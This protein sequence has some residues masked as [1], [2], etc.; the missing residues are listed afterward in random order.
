MQ[1]TIMITG[2]SQIAIEELYT[3]VASLVGEVCLLKSKPITEIKGEDDADIFICGITQIDFLVQ[4]VPRNKIL[5][6]EPRFTAEFF[7]NV[8]K[9]PT[10]ADVCVFH[11]N[12]FRINMIIQ[13]LKNMGFNTLNFIPVADTMPKETIHEKLS[14]VRYIISTDSFLKATLSAG[15]PYHDFL[16]SDSILIGGKRV[17]SMESAC[18]IIKWT[19]EQYQLYL[20]RHVQVLKEQLPARV[21]KTTDIA[22]L[23]KQIDEIATV[24]QQRLDQL[25]S[26]IYKAFFNQISPNIKLDDSDSEPMQQ[27][28]VHSLKSIKQLIDDINEIITKLPHIEINSSPSSKQ[29]EK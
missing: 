7:M 10:G 20:N 8:A 22:G 27:H 21:S 13:G 14:N 25:R 26:I 15:C 16:N 28:I 3:S 24:S 2:S 11:S 18:Q 23:S 1:P 29:K 6:A 19:A 4:I 17:S 5:L 12:R 9:I